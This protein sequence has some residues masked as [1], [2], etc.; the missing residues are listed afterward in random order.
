MREPAA[1]PPTE[2][3][4][5]PEESP[6][7]A[8]DTG[9]DAEQ[10]RTCLWLAEV[11]S[12]RPGVV[13]RLCTRFDGLSGAIAQPRER[14]AEE[15]RRGARCAGT[16]ASTGVQEDEDPAE[17]AAYQALLA[18]A[19]KGPRGHGPG[20]CVAYV[21]VEY[22][23]RLRRLYDPPPALCVQGAGLPESLR[24]LAT[25]PVVGVVGARGPSAYGR[26]M[27]AAIATDLARAGVVVVSGLAMGI[28]AVAQQAALRAARHAGPATVGVLG[29]GVD[30]VYPRCNARL[31]AGVLARG[32]LLSEFVWGLHARAWRF[33]ARNRVIAGLC[34]ALVVVEGAERSGA[35][36]TA[37]FMNDLNGNVLAVPGEAGRRL[38]AGPHK[39][40]RDHGYLC[41]SAADVFALLHMQPVACA[42]AT[43]VAVPGAGADAQ[44]VLAL[45]D[46]G[47]RTADEFAA[48]AQVPVS[49]A[50]G[51]L[52][53]L[54]LEG[55]VQMSAGG[56]YRLV[57]GRR[58][59]RT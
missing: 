30:V 5:G 50:A 38:S 53:R 40:L 27:A 35:L 59:R 28:D 42:A 51:L 26:E 13:Q 21:D 23:E 52:S 8:A 48:V 2:S 9:V 25:G 46:S 4:V 11:A 58:P 15:L 6:G 39:I 20:V 29:C 16:Q 10:R 33:P 24:G 7:V 18:G 36:I 3:P 43:P 45:L 1:K 31:F 22:P 55:L 44:Q 19:A 12:V 34:D 47:E 54:E 41:E 49:A 56:R 17:A 37:G 57:R 14:L 32:L